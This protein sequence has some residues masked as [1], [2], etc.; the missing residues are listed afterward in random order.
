MALPARQTS[1]RRVVWII[2]LA[3]ASLGT[4]LYAARRLRPQPLQ[5]RPE[6]SI[7]VWSRVANRDVVAMPGR[8]LVGELA[9]YDDEFFAWLMFTYLSG[10][11][12]LNGGELLLSYS[13]TGGRIV[14]SLRIYLPNDLLSGIALLSRAQARGLA[15]EVSWNYVTDEALERLR[16]QTRLFRMAYDL[17]A[18]N[19]LETFKHA[20]LVAYVRRWVRF[21]SATDPRI[22]SQIAAAPAALNSDEARQLAED[23]VSVA[24][25]FELPLD[26]FLGIGA[27]ENNFSTLPAICSTRFGSGEPRR[28]TLF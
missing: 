1:T 2:V 8:S 16:G 26:F 9:R 21:K 7:P 3:M 18:R 27:M 19:K 11:P 6:A 22:R 10:A 24:T 20:E 15:R 4:A 28:A 25:F 23:I 12:E 14:Y 13:A 17:P 5:I